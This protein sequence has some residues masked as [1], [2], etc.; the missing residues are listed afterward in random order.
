MQTPMTNGDIKLKNYFYNIF[1]REHLKKPFEIIKWWNKGRFLLNAIVILYS[2]IHLII[3][4]FVFKNGF[5]IFLIP[6][7]FYL[8]ILVNVI[9]S[10]GL[11]F[12]L[13]LKFIFQSN[14]KF[15][16]VFSTIKRLEFIISILI[17][18]ALSIYGIITE[19]I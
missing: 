12:E 14:L 19:P 13:I 16:K 2:L 3:M 10:L 17:V 11:V 5:V 8:L 1:F 9:Y 7:I 6:I 15:D 18:L 4:F